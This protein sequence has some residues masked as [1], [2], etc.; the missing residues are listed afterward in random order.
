VR[1]LALVD[2]AAVHRELGDE[3]EAAV[4]GVIRTQQFIGG[5]RVISFEAAFADYVGAGEALGMAN[6]T[7]ALEIAVR[8][9]GI[10]PGA[11][12]L[13]PANT[14]IATAE[15]IVAAGATPRFVD[16][17]PHTG[18]ID[19]R[20]CEERVG[21]RTQ[22][23]IPVHL[24]GRMADMDGVMA[25]ARRHSLAVIEDA[26]QAHGAMRAGRRAG[27]IGHVGCFSF[28]PGKNL[29]AF[30]DAGAA[31][32]SDPTV[33]ARMRLL[34]DHGRR[35]RND[36]EIIGLNSRLD[37]LHAAVL[38]VKLAHLD[39]WNERRR[40]ASSWYRQMLSADLL[41][42]AA[43]EP[44]SDVHHVFPILVAE[45]DALGQRLG[46]AEV[47]AGIHYRQAIPC[48]PAFAAFAE[49][50]PTAERRADL[51]ISLPMHPHLR[52]EDVERVA[53]V[54]N[55]FLLARAA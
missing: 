53:S 13:V 42:P 19:L 5:E 45:R 3:L 15:A 9:V 16:V 28:Y 36:H 20:S 29:G 31:V 2:L 24:Y 47:Q 55:G 27:S 11:E 26:A 14:F 34:R 48:T 39:G 54:V 23:I 6:C 21:Q 43:A 44:A 40:Q 8:A 7:D 50:C 4:L 1:P 33:A 52:R 25:F 32:T 18:L 17:E 10:D 51:Q 46:E 12:I 41:D 30:G 38:A 37:P 22:A 35:A 49:P